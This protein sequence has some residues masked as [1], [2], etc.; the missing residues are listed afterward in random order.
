MRIIVADHV[1]ETRAGL[2]EGDRAVELH[3]ERWSERKARAIRGE[4][5]RARVRRVEPQLNG[6]FLDIG[7]GPDGFLPFGAQG[8]PAGF[9]EGAAIG[10]QIVREAFQEKRPDADAA[11]GGARRRA[12]SA[13]DGSA[14]A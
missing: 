7:R 14:L 1:G 5:Y 12:A 11:R 6:A 4:I 3:I 2:F 9:H 13:A 8:R 10:V